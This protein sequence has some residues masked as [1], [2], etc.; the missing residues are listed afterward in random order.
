MKRWLDARTCLSLKQVMLSMPDEKRQARE[1]KLGQGHREGRLC[2]TAGPQ[3][4]FFTRWL[5]VSSTPR[6]QVVQHCCST[7][8]VWDT[9]TWLRKHRGALSAGCSTGF[10]R[11]RC[12]RAG[13]ATLQASSGSGVTKDVGQKSIAL[14]CLSCKL[15]RGSNLFTE[16]IMKTLHQILGRSSFDESTDF[17]FVHSQPD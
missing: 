7:R 14:R 3:Q 6:M 1:R 16:Q 5:V 17:L 12:L 15:L 9:N 11:S 10:H 4:H 2:N 13:C 8:A